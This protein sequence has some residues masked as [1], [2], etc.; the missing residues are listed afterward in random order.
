MSISYYDIIPRYS[1]HGVMIIPK[2]LADRQT[3]TRVFAAYDA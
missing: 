3:D 2:T 1:E